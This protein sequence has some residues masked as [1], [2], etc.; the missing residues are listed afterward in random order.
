MRAHVYEGRD[1]L[2]AHVESTGGG[3]PA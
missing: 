1:V 3:I 2:I